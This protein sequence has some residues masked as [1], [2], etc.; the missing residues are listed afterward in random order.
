MAWWHL[1]P[2]RILVTLICL[3]RYEKLFGR[4]SHLNLCVTNAM[5][6]DLAENWRI[7]CGGPRVPAALRAEWGPR[8]G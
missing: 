4:L 3:Y 2:T 5:R 7:R 1:G 8:V 6:E